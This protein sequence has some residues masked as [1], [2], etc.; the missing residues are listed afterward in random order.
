MMEVQSAVPSINSIPVAEHGYVDADML[1]TS[2]SLA[3]SDMYKAEVPLYDDLVSIVQG[4]NGSVLQNV[5][6]NIKRITLERHGA[7]R[8]GSPHELRTVRRIF[9]LLGMHPVGYY[10]LSVAG[11]PMHATCFRP[12]DSQSLSKNPFRVF[13]TL[14][15]PELLHS[16]ESRELALRLLGRRRIFSHAL[17]RLMDTVDSQQG[18]FTCQQADTFIDEALKS[19]RW[20]PVA[21]AT[22]DEYN[23]LKDDH[24]I[25]ADIVC[26][27]TAH[28]NHL[29]PR[30][31]D[32]GLSQLAM[33]AHGM[34][35]KERIEGPPKRQCP[36]LL[37]Q[38]SFLALRESVRYCHSSDQPGQFIEGYHRAR[39]GE[40]E[41]RGAAL[42]PIGRKLFNELFEEA[43][44]I[45]R[46][47]GQKMDDALNLAF[48]RFPDNWPELYQQRLVYCEFTVTDK[49]LPAHLVSNKYPQEDL[50]EQL[51]S[52]G[53]LSR[54]PITYEDFLPFSAAGIF[55][56]NLDNPS[57]SA[58]GHK[59]PFPDQ[60]GF[61]ESLGCSVLDP[62]VLYFTMQRKSIQKCMQQLGLGVFNLSKSGDS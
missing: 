59:K 28:I 50:L 46:T 13:T 49:A 18:R 16:T 52:A 41:E 53:V 7:I 38:T 8:L 33:Q 25:L 54:A 19:F 36:I 56:S 55:Q 51:V 31:L 11:L 4:V 9:S 43:M 62:D 14:L 45:S 40:I 44:D 6:D 37:R 15:R 3:M 35:V 48:V 1:R 39:F 10:D 24:P 57:S 29:T 12:R 42:T 27:Q 60:Q 2:F 47:T 21:A 58:M 23:T 22:Y 20:Q 5:K 26:F 30:T 34:D 61:E 17:T 32:I